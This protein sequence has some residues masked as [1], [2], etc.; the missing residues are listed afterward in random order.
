MRAPDDRQ[1]AAMPGAPPGAA[2]AGTS[3]A[4]ADPPAPAGSDLSRRARA[5]APV[6]IVLAT[7]AANLWN[8]RASTTGV[9]FLNDSSVQEQMVRFATARLRAG[10]DPFTSWF[11]YLGLGSPQFLH[12]Q[13]AESVLTGIAGIVVGPNVAFRWSLYLL[14]SC[15][16]IAIFLA[17]RV[18][19]LRPF[20]AAAAAAVSPLLA[21]VPGVG[22]EP[23]AYLWIGYGVWAQLWASWALPFAWA[24]GWRAMG[25]RRFALPAAIAVAATAALHFETGY[26]A[27]VPLVFL[28][29]LVPSDLRERLVNAV[30]VAVGALLASA[31][32]ILPLLVL[33]KWASVNEALQG[34]PLVNGYGAH[35]VLGWLVAGRL[36]DNGHFPLV[37]LLAAAG[38]V[39]ALARWRT[40]HLGRALVTLT[41]IGLVLSFGRT[42]FGSLA[43]LLPGGTDVFFRRFAL[44]A[45]LGSI[46]LA[47]LGAS[48]LA[49]YGR[50]T[51]VRALER[52]RLPWRTPTWAPTA[53]VVAVGLVAIFPAWQA[54]GSYASANAN[55][56]H[57]QAADEQQVATEID[58]LVAYVL[59]HGGGR[60]YAGLPS[61]WGKTFTV[62]YVPV[63]EYLASR[64]IDV[65][66]FTLR[67]A[68]L[69]TGPE[70]DFDESNAGDYSLFGI[71]YLLLPPGRSEPVDMHLVAGNTA[72]QLYEVPADG[73]VQVVDTV[74]SLQ[75]NRTDI[76]RVSAAYL[77]SDLPG[78]ARYLVVGYAGAP[79]PPLSA[80]PLTPQLPPPGEVLAEH[81]DLADGTASVTAKL[82]RRAVVVLSASFDPGWTAT[83]DGIP[84]PTE[85]IAP[86]LV[87][88]EVGPGT[89]TIT[90]RY[91]G[92]SWY[93]E[94][95]ALALADLAALFLLTTAPGRRVA[96]RTAERMRGR[97][98]PVR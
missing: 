19:G 94:L 2:P 6:A 3:V 50:A 45:Q 4:G 64:D 28:P 42:T 13:S 17:A 82:V 51:T 46:L 27:F 15:W 93:P 1:A 89:H 26:L 22:Y 52:I 8:L 84:V 78:R 44:G 11:P 23:K 5:I 59:R 48:A 65:V 34:T 36:L 12:Y 81:V 74:G 95:A 79:P 24:F 63:Y 61:N 97:G 20:A 96:R 37:T 14:F 56:I 53:L 33:G 76:G 87:G 77:R 62:G 25:E 92:Y 29:F 66:G 90:F 30:V 80:S 67:T 57:L 55:D 16:P 32:V 54:T 98:R 73:Y 58:P 70:Y 75:E 49:S 69:M 18:F 38:A 39:V 43:D 10:H 88:A 40:E 68:S 9:A 7:V 85:M 41:C 83:V 91:V 86:A 72:Y 21:S 35:Q 60:V 31:W 71:R 47:G